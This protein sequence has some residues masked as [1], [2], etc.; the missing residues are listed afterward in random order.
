MGIGHEPPEQPPQVGREEQESQDGEP[1]LLPT[2]KP[3]SNL[4]VSGL[5]HFSQVGFGALRPLCKTSMTCPHFS[6]RYSNIGMFSI[7][8]DQQNV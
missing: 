5:P 2:E 1:E 4:L 6:H 7:L 8:R 3:E